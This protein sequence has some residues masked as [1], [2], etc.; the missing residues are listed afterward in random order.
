MSNRILLALDGSAMDDAAFAEAG[1]LAAGGA[2]IHL[3]HVVPSRAV[4]V[5]TPLM[6]MVDTVRARPVPVGGT[7]ADAHLSGTFPSSSPAEALPE[8]ESQIHGQAAG[9]LEHFRSRLPG[10]PGQDLVRTGSPVD[11]ILE[12][13]LVFNIDLIVMSTHARTG[14]RRWFL[15]SVS[16]SVLQRSQ[17]PVLL[18]RE[19]IPARSERLRRILVPIFG[20]QESRAI[21]SAVKPLAVRV[22]AEILLL[23][24]VDPRYQGPGLEDLGR[25]L[26]QS[27]ASWRSL[28]VHGDPTEEILHH[29]KS[30]NADLIAM[31]AP[32][33]KGYR[34]LRRSIADA[35]LARTD[36]AI[37]LQNPV[38]HG[39]SQKDARPSSKEIR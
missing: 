20:A 4:P 8:V 38:I 6:G 32:A 22:N 14:I 33:R 28:T 26:T 15:G 18:V 31:S 2:E 24:V 25:E 13:A 21:L 16:D 30:H 36:R 11:A 17:L 9:Y 23:Q 7:G 10:V 1:K 39:S 5:G 37:L 19:G 35:V 34:L 29:A 27:G 12:V 3:L